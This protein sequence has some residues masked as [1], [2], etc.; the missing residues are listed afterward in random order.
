MEGLNLLLL[1][2]FDRD[3]SDIGTTRGLDQGCRI[4]FVSLVPLDVCSNIL[5]RQKMDLVAQRGDPPRPVVG[6]T[7]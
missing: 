6:T 1:D 4:R 3:W 7:A 5:R 2:G